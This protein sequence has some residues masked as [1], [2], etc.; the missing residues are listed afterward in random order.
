[1]TSAQTQIERVVANLKLLWLWVR[2]HGV[3]LIFA[4]LCASAALWLIEHDA[5][6]RREFEL[7]QLRTETQAEVADLRARAAA[8][9][10]ELQKNARLIENLESKRRDLERQSQDLRQR[11]SHLREEERL[12]VQQAST[13]APRE[14][15]QRV[16]ARLGPGGQ[17]SGS[18]FQVSGADQGRPDTRHPTPDTSG[19]ANPEP[20]IPSHGLTLTGQGLRGVETAFLQLDACREQSAVK[21]QM[22]SN[23]EARV[24]TAQTEIEKLNDS[25]SQLQETVRLKDQIAERTEAAHRAELVAARGTWRSRFVRVLKYVGVGVVIG[26]AVR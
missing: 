5:R 19:A 2:A 6:L 7:Q 10:G 23:C 3:L 17:V 13:L 22:V 9:M 15:A 25:V 12:R 11:L 21:D 20:R 14:L 1:M 16:A 8:A 18:G 24:G 4:V 26:V